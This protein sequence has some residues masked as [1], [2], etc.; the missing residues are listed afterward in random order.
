MEA[1]ERDVILVCEVCGERTALGGPLAV[2]RSENTTFGC[3]CGERLTLANRLDSR[4]SNNMLTTA[5]T[6]TPTSLLQP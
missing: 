4:E 2:W 3:E 6:K 5:A 1:S